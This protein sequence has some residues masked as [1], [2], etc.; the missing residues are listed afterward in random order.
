[1]PSLVCIQAATFAAKGRGRTS[2]CR[3]ARSTVGSLP[4]RVGEEFRR[5]GT[6]CRRPSAMRRANRRSAP[7]ASIWPAGRGQRTEPTGNPRSANSAAGLIRSGSV[8]APACSH[9]QLVGGERSRHGDGERPRLLSSGSALPLRTYMSAVAAA[10]AVSR[11]SM[12]S[13]SPLGSRPG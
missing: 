6:E 1:M 10:G 13:S 7:A 11:P 12:A 2:R 9:R 8:R 5:L 4:G 3:V